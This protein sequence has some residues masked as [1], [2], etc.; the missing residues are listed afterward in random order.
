VRINSALVSAQNRE[1]YYWTDIRT[2]RE[3]LFGELHAD[4]PQPPDRGILLEDIVDDEV[5]AKYYLKGKLLERVRREAPHLVREK[6]Y[7][8]S[9]HNNT[10]GGGLRRTMTVIVQRGRGK[11]KG[12]FHNE[13]SPTLT[14]SGFEQNNMVAQ[15]NPSRES[16]SCPYQQNRVYDVRGKSPAHMA[17][18]SYRSYAISSFGDLRRL[19]PTECARLQTI[20][21]WYRWACSDT[22]Q[23]RLLG[24]G[25][26]VEVIKHILSFYNG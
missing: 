17:S 11:N 14:T 21:E 1:R 4:I 3:G 9:T 5:D 23:Y 15:L 24:N 19:T 10:T 25:W 18:M 6:A 26:T 16:G 13:K 2:R 8:V 22:Q 7:C 12:G 20:P